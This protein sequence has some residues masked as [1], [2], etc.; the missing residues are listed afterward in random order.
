MVIMYSN[1][2]KIRVTVKKIALRIGEKDDILYLDIV[3]SIYFN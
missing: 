1:A 3:Y 2:E